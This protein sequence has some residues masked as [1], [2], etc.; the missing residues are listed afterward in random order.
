MLDDVF[1]VFVKKKTR[2][3]FA[4]YNGKK[5]GYN[6]PTFVIN[7]LSEYIKLI[8]VFSSIY[9][10]ST[11][12][13]TVIYRGIS[14]K[15]YA[16][17]PGLSRSKN[18]DDN[19]ERTLINEYL[20][21]CPNAFYGLSDFDMIAKMQHYGLPTR[22]LDFTL[23]PLVAL[24]FACESKPTKDGRVI[25]HS[26]IV[27]NYSSLIAN[28]LCSIVVNKDFDVAK[29]V[30][31]HCCYEKLSFRQ[32]IIDSYLC[33]ETTVI[34]PKYWNQRITNQEG[35]FM[36]FFNTIFDSFLHPLLM[37]EEIG[38]DEA[39]RQYGNKNLSKDD[40]QK[41][42]E[43]EPIDYYR[44][45]K[46]QSVTGEYL[47]RMLNSYKEKNKE[48]EFWD[49]LKKRLVFGPS[50]K[51]NALIHSNDGFNSLLCELEANQI[52]DDFCSVIVESK[53]KR[54]I[55]KELSSVGIRADYI[56]PELEYSAKEIRRRYE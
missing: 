47:R 5:C 12:N 27:Q 25:C 50:I 8:K 41:A 45:V 51:R 23:N 55:L 6:H 49:L 3:S 48:P 34:R 56:Y 39:I 4:L 2:N 18:L 46:K 26:T 19:L 32:L 1:S 17:I 35:V 36:F 20:T 21:R 38:I 10:N 33:G 14:D 40:I 16:M 29:T 42:L 22:L 30:D 9:D 24:Y 13:N 37:S 15:A 54:K 28:E 7:D 43:S 31:E 52:E 53:Q 11:T 44:R